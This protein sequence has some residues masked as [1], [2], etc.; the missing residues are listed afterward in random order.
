MASS[1]V[2]EV[3]A[4][5]RVLVRGPGSAFLNADIDIMSLI[6]DRLFPDRG[7][8]KAKLSTVCKTLYNRYAKANCD[9]RAIWLYKLHT[10]V[11]IQGMRDSERTRYRVGNGYFDWRLNESER[12]LCSLTVSD[13]TNHD[14]RVVGH[15]P[16]WLGM[17][18][19]NV[20]LRN[21]HI[22][23]S[24][25][26]RTCRHPQSWRATEDERRYAR[27]FQ[28]T[29]RTDVV[30]FDVTLEPDALVRD[31]T[32]VQVA[33]LHR[34]AHNE[35][36]RISNGP[37]S[38]MMTRNMPC[39]DRLHT[40]Q[41]PP[42]AH[43][44]ACYAMLDPMIEVNDT[45]MGTVPGYD[46]KQVV[47]ERRL[48]QTFHL[49]ICMQGPGFVTTAV[50]QLSVDACNAPFRTTRRVEE[51]IAREKRAFLR[52]NDM[53]FARGMPLVFLVEPVQML[54]TLNAKLVDSNP[55][56]RDD[57]TGRMPKWHPL[58]IDY[59]HGRDHALE[60]Q[61]DLCSSSAV[62][63]WIRR[64]LVGQGARHMTNGLGDFSDDEDD[65]ELPNSHR[66]GG[67]TG[68]WSKQ[69]TDARH[70]PNQTIK[71]PATVR[72]TSVV[73]DC[74]P[75]RSLASVRVHQPY[76]AEFLDAHVSLSS[77]GLVRLR[78]VP[79]VRKHADAV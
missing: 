53:R 44:V 42:T 46:Q 71:A 67:R 72:W 66:P 39:F 31:W 70:R 59:E 10:G 45:E 19:L 17:D 75:P 47:F 69:W 63:R 43:V 34:A 11:Q 58:M 49:E 20:R 40:T 56:S 28:Y 12:R 25:L 37:S 60:N 77:D 29:K 14:T 9:N 78:I 54:G 76:V 38:M 55:Y 27:M 16:R 30:T 1:A 7:Y 18:R 24:T 15:E 33:H 13:T 50:G 3:K 51:R 2:R 48:L 22:E 26:R 64:F 36:H 21:I 6:L 61:L 32:D 52:L 5:R 35:H 62:V 68:Y 79:R 73:Y 65:D 4:R 57:E 8:G 23:S 41:P 74:M